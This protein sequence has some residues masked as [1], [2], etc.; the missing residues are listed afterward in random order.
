MKGMMSPIVSGPPRSI[1]IIKTI[2]YKPTQSKYTSL[3][4]SG[5]S[6]FC[7]IDKTKYYTPF[8]ELYSQTVSKLI[9]F[10]LKLLF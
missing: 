3:R 1:N 5:Y 4:F 8:E 9:S 6:R 7:Q 2:P 10:F